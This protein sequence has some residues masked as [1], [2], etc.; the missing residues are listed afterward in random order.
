MRLKQAAKKYRADPKIY[1]RSGG[2]ACP[3]CGVDDVEPDAWGAH[4][5]DPLI[6][7]GNCQAQWAEVNKLVGIEVAQQPNAL[8]DLYEAP[9]KGSP[10]DKG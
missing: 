3:F 7:C 8:E 2:S 6:R 4:G 9:A 10:M 5:H 1:I